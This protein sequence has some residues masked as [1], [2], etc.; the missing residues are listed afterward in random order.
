MRRRLALALTALVTVA[1]A[2]AA[3]GSGAMGISAGVFSASPDSVAF[4]HV[5]ASN[6]QTITETL[7]NTGSSTVT[8]SA[9]S[10]SGPDQGD[11]SLSNDNCQNAAVDP[12]QSCSVDV[13][14]TPGSNGP[15]SA[16]LDITDDDP[17]SPQSVPL[18]GTGVATEFSLSGPLT[19]GDQLVGSTSSS[20]PE[21]LTNNTDYA[22]NPSGPGVTGNAGDFNVDASACSGSIATTCTV[23][24]SFSP[25]S[26]G[27]RTATLTMAGQ[28]VTLTGNGVQPNASVSPGSV[29]FGSQPVHTNSA[30]TNITLSNT[31][32][33]N[34]SYASM[35][36]TG[37]NAGDFAVSDSDCRT[38]GVVLPGTS[39]TITA[40]FVPTTTGSRTAT[41]TLHD[42]D[43]NNPTQTVTLSGTGTPSSVG[44]T[45]G[46]V[47]FVHPV[48]A[49]LPSPVHNVRI[50]NTTN[51]NLPVSGIKLAGANPKSFIRSAD[52]CS[53]QS[54]AAG[55]SCTVHVEFAPTAAGRRTAFLRIN[56][57]GPIGP[58]SH[59]ITL[60][61]TATN[62][63]NPKSV[64]GA[65]GCASTQINWV[66]PTAT[67]FAGVRIVRNA[68]HSPTGISDGK[69]IAHSS[70]VLTNTKLK[71]F[72]TYYYRVFASYHSKT[73]PKQRN[74]SAG[75]RLKA[76][77]GEICTPRNG[78]RVHDLT[79]TFTWLRS[80]TQNG[81][82]FVLQRGKTT[83]DINYTS[84]RT[85]RLRSSW[86]YR[87]NTHRLVR[88]N[89]YTFYLYAYP[90]SHPRGILI[91]H[92]SF[93]E[94]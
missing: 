17:S 16:S 57:T 75:V 1:I 35:D 44:F 8:I 94:R 69:V 26:T 22:D 58:H 43:P 6:P 32:S 51:S 61:G 65:V 23:N 11:F 30:T 3:T 73:H 53:G 78:A 34:L 71:H 74:Y 12:G 4:G 47:T 83:V 48:V 81:Y 79:P 90:A 70:G 82:A 40:T 33:S 21:I 86:R 10:L 37:A 89:G 84:R 7:T 63:N 64:R 55:G 2:L 36:V 13:K 56:D 28:P 31:G 80:S 62:P 49:G 66:A 68:S 45:P 29:S 88:G 9:D 46:S 39:C 60:T 15:E 42:G 91:G 54:L 67:R 59:E 14:F 41:I 5:A 19:F 20:Q 18:S 72:T 85:W 38:A 24:V 50:T 77:T 93:S 87:G 76:R 25:Q 92:V 27:T 52:T